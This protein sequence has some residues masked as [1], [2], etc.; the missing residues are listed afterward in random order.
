MVSSTSVIL[1]L[2]NCPYQT[3]KLVYRQD[4]HFRNKFILQFSEI[5]N[6]LRNEI[7]FFSSFYMLFRHVSEQE[8]GSVFHLSR[9][10]FF[11]LL[12]DHK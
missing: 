7:R 1:L 11:L 10:C 4:E 5:T 3:S 9:L 12:S 6:N 8:N 2:Q